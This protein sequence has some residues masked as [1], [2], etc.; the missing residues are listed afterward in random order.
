MF[1]AMGVHGTSAAT[2]V[3][4]QNSA[5]FRSATGLPAGLVVTQ[6]EAVLDDLRVAAVKTGMLWTHGVAIAVATVARLGRLPALVVDPVLASGHGVRIVDASLD[7]VYRDELFPLAA[8]VTPNT[9]EAGFLLDRTVG[10]VD[11]AVAAAHQIAAWGSSAVV[12]TGGRRPGEEA[13]D[14]VLVDGEISFLRVPW[15]DTPNVRGSGDTL[16]A[17]IAARLA[18]GDTVAD[19]ISTAHRATSLA[20]QAGA[21]WRLGRGQGPVDQ[22]AWLDGPPSPD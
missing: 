10:S 12:L 14:V 6:I 11:D 8:V 2:V 3:T 15:V 20:I 17:A 1:A 13:V 21:A 9:I 5:E 4:A 7:D 19:A 16:S 22:L 18:L